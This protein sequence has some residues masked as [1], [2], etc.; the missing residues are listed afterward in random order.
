MK[1]TDTKAPIG[2]LKD[3]LIQMNISDVYDKISKFSLFYDL[4]VEYNKLFNLTTIT[5]IID[6]EQKHYIDS[7][8]GLDLISGNVL[9][10]GAGAGFPSIPLAIMRD[11]LSFTL[12]ESVGKKA[13]FLRIV[14]EKLKLNN[15]VVENIRIEDFLAKNYTKAQFDTVVARAVAPLNTLL[16]YSMPFLKINGRLIAYKGSNV[17]LEITEANNALN[18]LNAKIQNI[19]DYTIV[20]N[21]VLQTRNIL[22]I[23][24]LS[25]TDKKYPRPKNKPRLKPL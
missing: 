16:E 23:I 14:V 9:D 3:K 24:K 7:L 6:V 2:A 13:N 15:V 1:Y 19:Y 11:D 5:N 18:I 8:A 4:L 12:I 20:D 22:D 10:I 25:E 17:K 21:Q